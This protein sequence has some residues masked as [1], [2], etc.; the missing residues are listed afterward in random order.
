MTETT[1]KKRFDQRSIYSKQNKFEEIP[2]KFVPPRQNIG[3][4]HYSTILGYN[5]FK[6]PEK[7]K[8]EIEKGHYLK[9]YNAATEFGIQYE[10]TARKFYEEMTGSVVKKSPWVR[11]GRILG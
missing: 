3:P 2:K 6:T 7:L 4:S 1:A 5:S 9:E 8:Y 11:S 10:D